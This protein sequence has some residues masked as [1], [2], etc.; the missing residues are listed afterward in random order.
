VGSRDTASQTWDLDNS[1][2]VDVFDLLTLLA[3]WGMCP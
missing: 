2:L 1:G 3:D